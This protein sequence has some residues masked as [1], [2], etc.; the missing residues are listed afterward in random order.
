MKDETIARW[1]IFVVFAVPL[2][3]MYL[4]HLAWYGA[5]SAICPAQYPVP[6]RCFLGSI[7]G[8]VLMILSIPAG[9]FHWIT[10]FLFG[11]EDFALNMR[12]FGL[13]IP[14]V[15]AVVFYRELFE[16]VT[17]LAS[18]IVRE[19]RHDPRPAPHEVKRAAMKAKRQAEHK[20]TQTEMEEAIREMK[21][22]KARLEALKRNQS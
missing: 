2:G 6:F 19:E 12:I 21:E 7:V 8:L 14:A 16:I 10:Q 1:G 4:S 5:T 15:A 13:S 18:F 11:V 22:A 17:N 9:I 20:Q 3:L